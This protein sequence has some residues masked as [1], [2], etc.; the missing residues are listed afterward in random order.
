MQ[1]DLEMIFRR[2]T[3][4]S[5]PHDKQFSSI[6]DLL[7]SEEIND[8]PF[9]YPNFYQW[10][11]VTEKPGLE[12]QYTLMVEWDHGRR[13]WVVGYIKDVK[14]GEMTLPEWESTK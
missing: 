12:W 13:W 4:I 7:K 14:P 10:S 5:K 6:K 9:V 1:G 8:W 2:K 3:P 11:V